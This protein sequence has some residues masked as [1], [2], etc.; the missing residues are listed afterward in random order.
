MKTALCIALILWV[1]WVDGGTVRTC[2]HA[3]LLAFCCN[4]YLY[5]KAWYACLVGGDGNSGQVW[6]VVDDK[7]SHFMAPFDMP[8]WHGLC[9]VWH[10]CL[11][12]SWQ[13][14][15]PP[16]LL[17]LLYIL[18]FYSQ[19]VTVST[20]GRMPPP[21]PS[22]SSVPWPLLCGLPHRPSPSTPPK[23]LGPLSHYT[24]GGEGE[25]NQTWRMEREEH[26]PGVTRG[27]GAGSWA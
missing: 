26:L 16:F 7:H 1:E 23:T 24:G 19:A 14:G 11:Y 3:C 15:M 9:C 12:S 20:G 4:L 22:Q 10:N 25:R 8:F 5:A 2:H 18:A 17:S 13:A 21:I 27:T 6:M